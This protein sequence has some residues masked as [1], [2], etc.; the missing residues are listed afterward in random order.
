MASA[1]NEADTLLHAAG[2]LIG[3]VLLEAG[4]ADEIEIMG[5][6]VADHRCRR[7]GERQPET[8]RWRRPSSTATG[9]KCWN[10]MATPCGDPLIGAPPSRSLPP[11]TSMR[12]AMQRSS[13]VLPQPLGPT[14]HSVSRSCTS[15]SSLAECGPCA[16]EKQLAR[17]RGDDDGRFRLLCDNHCRP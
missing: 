13:V 6:A 4:K 5:D 9:P 11:L 2:E 7:A 15:R 8:R 3:I 1:A 10:T 12:P 16:V 14:M 17:V